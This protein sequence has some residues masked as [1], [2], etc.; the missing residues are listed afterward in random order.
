MGKIAI[1]DGILYKSGKLE[2]N[3]FEEMKHHV[4]VGAE[5][6]KELGFMDKVAEI[7]LQHHERVDGKGYPK[8]LTGGQILLEA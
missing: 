1:R 8:G 2:D 4:I 7:I 3:E 5:I 6:I